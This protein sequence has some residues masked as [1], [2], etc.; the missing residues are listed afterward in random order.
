MEDNVKKFLDFLGQSEGADYD[1]IVGGKERITDFS[2]HPKIVGL[3]TAEGPSTAAGKYQITGTTYDRVA[4][5]LGVSDFSPE[6]QDRIALE[7]IKERG[8]F[9][10]VQSGNWEAAINKLGD[11]W[12]SLPSSKYSQPKR[13]WAFVQKH[14]GISG[15][16]LPEMQFAS[17]SQE[18]LVPTQG[19]A[20]ADLEMAEARRQAQYGGLINQAAALPEAIQYGFENENAVLNFFRDQ[21]LSQFDP[22]FVW[23][24]ERTKRALEGIPRENWDYVLQAGSDDEI[25]TRRGRISE[26]LKRQEELSQM[27][28]VGVVGTLT[29]ALVD[30]PT[31]IG[32]VPV[33]GGLA[34]VSRTSRVANAL[35]SGLASGA[36]NVAADAALLK[37]RPL[38]STDELYFSAA[39]GLGFGALAGGIISPA[40][41]AARLA[42]AEAAANMRRAAGEMA[43]IITEGANR[44]TGRA[45]LE[46]EYLRLQEYGQREA[47]RLQV[48]EL[49]DA[50]FVLTDKG[51]SILSSRGLGESEID[52]IR[53]EWRGVKV[54]DIPQRTPRFDREFEAGDVAALR[55][56]DEAPLN[57]KGVPYPAQS[58]RAILREL[59][60]NASD[61]FI[62]PLAKRV[63][64]QLLDDV[65][66]YYVPRKFMPEVK[67]RGNAAGYYDKTRHHILISDEYKG[68]GFGETV[69]LHEIA[70]A[71]TVQKLDYGRANRNTVHGS[72]V[73]QLEEA[74]MEAKIAARRSGM[75]DDYYLT[76]LYEFTA[77]LY[78][79]D[80]K[81]LDLLARTKTSG[82][83]LLS[84]VVDIVR[85]ILGLDSKETNLLL[86]SL[87]L[88]DRLMDTRLDVS[89]R[90]PGA[91]DPAV[92]VRT[93]PEDIHVK[94]PSGDGQRST[95]TIYRGV[96]DT[97]D[98]SMRG[99]IEWWSP[100][101]DHAE[102]YARGGGQVAKV[103]VDLSRFRSVREE[104]YSRDVLEAAYSD[105]SLDGLSVTRDGI[106]IIHATF[107]RPGSVTVEDLPEPPFTPMQGIQVDPATLKAVSHAELN[108][109]FGWSFGL[110]HTLRKVKN[111]PKAKALADKLLGT[112]VGY[113]GHGVVRRNAYDQS[114][115]LA[116]GWQD[117]V[118]KVAYAQFQDYMKRSGKRFWERDEVVREW[119]EQLGNY[120]RGF[121]GDYD[122]TVITT[123][124]Q[125]RK[126]LADVVDHINNPAKA[127][128]GS[129]RGLTQ[130][131]Y[132]DELGNELLTDPLAKSDN[133]LPR[134]N[135]PHKWDQ[136]V[137]QFGRQFVEDWW[138]GAFKAAN[139]EV[140]DKIAQRFGKWYVQRVE[141]G[142]KNGDA[143]F[144]SENLRGLDK[145]ALKESMLRAGLDEA[146][147]QELLDGMFPKA[148]KGEGALV[149]NTKQR[150]T[151]DETFSMDAV[152]NGERVSVTMN[153][154]INTDTLGVLDGYFRRMGGAISLANH[155][156]IYK[157]S[158]I[159]K[160]ILEATTVQ[161]GD[162][163][164][165]STLVKL[166]DDFQFTFD[167]LL[168]RPVEDFSVFNKGMEMWRNFNV[169]R[170]M[171]AA[172][173]NQIQELSQI[174]GTMGWKATLRAL[175][176]LGALRR[177]LL[178][179]KVANPLLDDLE[180]M[181]GGAGSDIIHRANF[182]PSEDWVRELG[183][184]P[185]NRWLDKA[186][187][188]LRR[189]ADGVLKYTGMT[190][191]MV[192]QKRIHAIVFTNHFMD[193][194]TKGKKMGLSKE[195]LAWMGLGDSDVETITA[196]MRKFATEKTG[197]TGKKVQTVDFDKWAAEDPDSLS[198]FTTAFQRESRRVVQENDL[199]S[200][201]P[202][203]TQGWAKTT[204]QFLNF[205]MQ[206]WNK[207]LLFG[208][209]HRDFATLSTVMHGALFASLVYMA[210]TASQMAGM[211]EEEK[212]DFAERRLS[213]KQIVANGF[214]RLAQASLL[215]NIIDQISPVPIFSGMR[216]TSDTSDFL[217]S[218][219]TLSSI[220]T[221]FS[222]WRKGVRNSLSDNY[223]TTERDARSYIRL[224]PL[225]NV[226]GISGLYNALISDLP[227]NEQIIPDE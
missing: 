204:F 136:M 202:V 176:Q 209:H 103:E 26:A 200:Q 182:N 167:R 82:D 14:L 119:N 47:A 221:L 75:E 183:D 81:F 63:A 74:F 45:P 177:D 198:K 123:G 140:S 114:L 224:L 104:D 185:F 70:H 134:A 115:Q 203:M 170:L 215:P 153:N 116:G 121:E 67:G 60:E 107:T 120:V 93:L 179:G 96:S 118:R 175:P 145:E 169:I 42:A 218:N 168:H 94:S 65:K 91:A 35:A 186:D 216:T 38:G 86:K 43:D 25:L 2:K 40:K 64:D 41:H 73:T 21:G 150:S 59:S 111:L 163:V 122:K 29:G 69:R 97:W 226:V 27:G 61:R 135:D 31:L 149:S 98:E 225:N 49:E 154:F 152:V 191:M 147:A 9:E 162:E 37:Y 34:M 105:S 72:L 4:K 99:D 206:A 144:L 172:V 223:Q 95:T 205:V 130:D 190:G 48:K 188:A 117:S 155:A 227:K 211:S 110:E 208:M 109:V 184:T 166:R 138:A 219:P 156:D 89:I 164:P 194:A 113:K 112:T 23:T 62:G 201:I 148:R 196:N 125:I 7:L 220:N 174:I 51:R 79:G 133:Y 87:D 141:A 212:R 19:P 10:D 44:Y 207:S 84:K 66:V 181:I 58:A 146:D 197:V 214:G 161:L 139:P 12:A 106:P 24:E 78:S 18:P 55:R 80:S 157:Q 52:V 189:S 142:K 151:I 36:S 8:A 50:G 137:Q 124:N 165:R 213:T 16:Q 53:S 143:D 210:R 127:T 15:G 101:R 32:F 90:R 85:K 102:M 20:Q 28:G 6:T 68:S 1:V 11:E 83:T 13:D 158:D 192:Q 217:T 193:V 178:S 131:T 71:V 3:R 54:E 222:A 39:A 33:I 100:S 173:Y 88:T 195:R 171:G 180:N 129:K 159:G 92:D 30:L 126:T 46:S 160:T 77:G 57:S 132:L 5:K 108:D 128:G 199:A 187:N 56:G 17:K 22:D 76:N